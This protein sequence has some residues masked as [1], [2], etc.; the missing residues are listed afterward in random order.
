MAGNSF[1][2]G[3]SQRGASARTI[4]RAGKTGGGG[5]R[6]PPPDSSRKAGRFPGFKA[7]F[8]RPFSTAKG[9]SGRLVRI[10]WGGKFHPW[11]AGIGV[12]GQDKFLQHRPRQVVMQAVDLLRAPRHR[13]RRGSTRTLACRHAG[14]R[15]RS[16]AVR[17]ES[18]ARY[19]P[20]PAPASPRSPG[21]SRPQARHRARNAVAESLRSV[22]RG[23]RT[24]RRRERPPSAR[25]A[26]VRRLALRRRTSSPARPRRPR[27]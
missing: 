18:A 12:D 19:G 22:D 23:R 2:S 17:G 10:R 8:S 21:R 7:R 26:P 5:S 24:T 1:A 13:R 25:C 4:R 16:D 9:L 14:R 27:L 3:K 6:K 15:P 20:A 11:R